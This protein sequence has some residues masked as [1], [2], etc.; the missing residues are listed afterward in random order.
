[1]CFLLYGVFA[2]RNAVLFFEH[3]RKVKRIV[4]SYPGSDLSNRQIL[5]K[6]KTGCFFKAKAGKILKQAFSCFPLEQ[7]AQITSIQVD[8]RRERVKRDM[9][10][11]VLLKVVNQLA[12][13]LISRFDLVGSRF[14]QRGKQRMQQAAELLCALAGE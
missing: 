1:M 11:I 5:L 8:L 2:W 7:P 3:P 12:H 13:I 6:Q 4:N 14:Q 9:L 10:R